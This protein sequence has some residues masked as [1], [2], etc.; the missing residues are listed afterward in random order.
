MPFR[1]GLGPQHSL[2]RRLR[3]QHAA[4]RGGLSR[5]KNEIGG[6]LIGP[7]GFPLPVAKIVQAAVGFYR[8]LLQVG[9]VKRGGLCLHLRR[10]RFSHP[11]SNNLNKVT[12]MGG[13]KLRTPGEQVYGLIKY[14]FVY[15]KDLPIVTAQVAFTEAASQVLISASSVYGGLERISIRDCATSDRSS[16]ACFSDVISSRAMRNLTSA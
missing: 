5:K 4:D 13:H 15:R 12:V 3:Q 16:S 6:M 1:A 9:R 10:A 14:A 8:L 11:L 7:V 2:Q